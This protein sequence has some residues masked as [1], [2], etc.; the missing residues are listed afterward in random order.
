MTP[1]RK[2]L[3]IKSDAKNLK[4]I[5]KEHTYSIDYYQREYLWEKKHV[6]ELIN[7][8]ANK[9]LSNYSEGDDT[10]LVESYSPY[11]M[12]SFIISKKGPTNYI[13]DG[14]QRLTSLTLLFAYLHN[15]QK[16]KH[17]PNVEGYIRSEDYAR[18]DYNIRVDDRTSVMDAIMNQMDLSPFEQTMGSSRN[19]AERYKDIEE[20]FPKYILDNCLKHFLYWLINRVQLVEIVAYSDETAYETFETMNDRGLVL[21]PSDMLNGYILS[22]IEDLDKRAEA[23][24]IWKSEL[25]SFEEEFPK[26]QAS[27]FL[28]DWFRGKYATSTNIGGENIPKNWERISI[29]F[30]R[31]FRDEHIAI[32]LQKSDD[33]YTFIKKDFLFYL[34]LYRI[35]CRAENEMLDGLEELSYASMIASP[36]HLKP[37]LISSALID[38]TSEIIKRKLNIIAL[39]LDSWFIRRIWLNNKPGADDFRRTAVR[40]VRAFRNRKLV[41]VANLCHNL[42]KQSDDS[43]WI[44]STPILTSSNKKEIFRILARLTDFLEQKSTKPSNFKNIVLGIGKNKY[45]IEHLWPEKYVLYKHLFTDEEEFKLERNQIGGLVLL[46]RTF[47]A[48]FNDLAYEEKVSRYPQHNRLAGILHNSFYD[49]EGRFINNVGLAKFALEH[50]ELKFQSHDTFTKKALRQRNEMYTALVKHIWSAEQITNLSGISS[51]NSL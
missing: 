9:F 19:I 5:L 32:G 13:V 44:A 11:F 23:A 21:T 24:F 49:N 1:Q 50:P 40:L 16:G 26:K 3:P 7:D 45:E 20:V 10:E 36:H 51:S 42:L 33:Y 15:K 4:E 31:W 46:E 6:E 27:D 47:N 48:S 14:Q 43:N 18:F 39:T 28:R 29:E 25:A 35:L 41:E 22:H 37:I 2:D 8:L 17:A 30:H 38:D 34:N 12:G